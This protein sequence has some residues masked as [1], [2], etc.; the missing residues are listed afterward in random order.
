[1]KV[2]IVEDSRPMRR[3]LRQVVGK[4]A[5]EV[6]ECSD[7]SEALAAYG[8]RRPNWVLMDIKME[9]CDGLMATRKI[10]ASF[11]D[12]R[13][14]IVSNYDD[15]DMRQAAHKAGAVGFVAKDNLLDLR[16]LLAAKA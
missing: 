14:V 16:R 6:Y 8:E 11:P 1:M 15:E 12:A 5:D 10:T 13:V 9:G 4:L 7:G 2:L 3:I